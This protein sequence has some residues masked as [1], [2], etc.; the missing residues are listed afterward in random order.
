[1][2]YQWY[3]TN[4]KLQ[5]TM[6]YCV[7][8]ILKNYKM[9]CKVLNNTQKFTK[10]IYKLFL[11]ILSTIWDVSL[12]KMG[13]VTLLVPIYGILC[14]PWHYWC[15]CTN[16]VDGVSRVYWCTI[17]YAWWWGPL[18]CTAMRH[19]VGISW[20]CDCIRTT[21]SSHAVVGVDLVWLYRLTWCMHCDLCT[22]RCLIVCCSPDRR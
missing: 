3:N 9:H 16:L 15:V 13:S 22:C 18:G 2:S 1:M 11:S 14:F 5:K 19:W 17:R 4:N 8:R 20:S 10:D 21:S 7:S 12:L 6:D